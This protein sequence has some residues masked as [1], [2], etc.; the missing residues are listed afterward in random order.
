[1]S[2]EKYKQFAEAEMLA[3]PTWMKMS[4]EVTTTKIHINY[5]MWI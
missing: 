2:N 4:N 1:M 3:D 5:G